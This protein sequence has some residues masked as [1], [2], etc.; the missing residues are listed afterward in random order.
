MPPLPVVSG[1]ECI[2]ALEKAG[3]VVVR[4]RGSHVVLQWYD[5]ASAQIRMVIVPDHRTLDRGT[6]RAIIRSSGLTVQ[7]FTDYL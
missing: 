7:E 4:Q 6:L 2:A 1:Q 3:F 5:P